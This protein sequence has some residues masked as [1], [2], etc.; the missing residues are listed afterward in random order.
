MKG[1]ISNSMGLFCFSFPFHIRT[2]RMSLLSR[3]IVHGRGAAIEGILKIKH[4]PGVY[5]IDEEQKPVTFF[6][7]FVSL[8]FFNTFA[9]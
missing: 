3:N 9:N 8:L 5:N 4:Q 2:K 6:S 7:L 1:N